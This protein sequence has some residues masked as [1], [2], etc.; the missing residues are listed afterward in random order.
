MN[1]QQAVDAQLLNRALAGDAAAFGDL[2]E[3]HLDAI[4]HYVFYRVN[5][6]HEAEDL[7][8]NIFLR[9]WQALDSHPP[10]EIPFRL[11][12][13]RIA[14]NVVVDYYRTRQEQIGLEAAAHLADPVEGPEATVVRQERATALKQALKQLTE[15]HQQ[16]LTCRFIVGLSH[17]ET[18]VV[19]TRNEEA[20]RALQYRAINA[21]RNLL[22]TQKGGL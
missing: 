3:R 20:V 10:R 11:W 21:L 5:G 4:Y 9:A 13:Y 2:Y 8:E 15:D 22:I 12:L 1:E 17:A 19:M 16:V 14:H 7:T 18:A 6:R